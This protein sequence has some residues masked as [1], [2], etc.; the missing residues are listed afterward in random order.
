MRSYISMDAFER[1][2]VKAKSDLT[3]IIGLFGTPKIPISE[4]S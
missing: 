3:S 1:K 4:K 2:T